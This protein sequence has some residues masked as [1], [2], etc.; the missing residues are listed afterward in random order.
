ME[1][2]FLDINIH[3]EDKRMVHKA[4]FKRPSKQMMPN[5]VRDVCR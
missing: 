3:T 2:T 1:K 4:R 5:D